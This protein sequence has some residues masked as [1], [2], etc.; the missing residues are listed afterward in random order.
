MADRMDGAVLKADVSSGLGFIRLEIPTLL[1]EP[2]SGDGWIHEIKYDG[3]RTLIVIDEGRVRAFTRNGN[4]WTAAYRRVVDAC[5]RLD[6]RTA[7]LDGEIVVQDE[8][9]ITDFHAPRSAISLR[10]IN[11]VLCL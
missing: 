8:H 4:D 3:Y 10:R 1:P 6:C 2:P 9:G 5:G 11:R 7:L